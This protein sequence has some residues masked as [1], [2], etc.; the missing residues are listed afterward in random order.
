V[1]SQEVFYY[2]KAEEIL[3]NV[4]AD[5]STTGYQLLLQSQS[6]SLIGG[7]QGMRKALLCL[8]LGKEG[9]QFGSEL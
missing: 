6:G 9:S 4:L 2:F 8:L 3:R 5:D 7:P 1:F